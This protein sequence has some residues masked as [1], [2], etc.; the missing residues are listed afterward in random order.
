MKS[1][2][3]EAQLRAEAADA[4]ARA[5]KSYDAAMAGLADC[6]DV[7]KTREDIIRYSD[8]THDRRSEE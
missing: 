8:Q 3:P 6:D 2:I 5:L 1:P 7:K 4:E